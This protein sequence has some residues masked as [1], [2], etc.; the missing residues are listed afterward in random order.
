MA[1][2]AHLAG[3]QADDA[4]VM[5]AIDEVDGTDRLVIADVSDDEAWLSTP[6]C[7]GAALEAWR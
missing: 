4:A 1:A 3:A 5:A 7:C 2:D 6:A